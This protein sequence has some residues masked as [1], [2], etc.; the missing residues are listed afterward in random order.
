MGPFKDRRGATSSPIIVEDRAVV[1]QDHEGGSFLGTFDMATGKPNWHADRTF[2]ARSYNTPV[3]WQPQEK[4]LLV[5]AGSGLL[6]A[7]D[8]QTGRAEWIV[9]GTSSVANATA[10]TDGAGRLFVAS[11]NPGP[12]REGQ[13]TF[14]KLVERD[15]ANSNGKLEHAE[16]KTGFLNEIFSEYDADADGV[17]SK[18]EHDS[19]HKYL[20]F[21]QNGMLAVSGLKGD[22]FNRTESSTLWHVKK[23]IPRT[24]SPIYHDGHLYCINDGGVFVSLNADTG[25]IAKMGRTPGGGKYFG[26]PVLGDGKIYFASDRGEVTV[27]SAEP[28][29][30]VLSSNTVGEPCY[31]SPA[32]SGGRVYIRTESKL[33]CF[34]VK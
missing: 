4:P 2:F 33:F 1:L 25:K 19:I 27:V 30:E 17:L 24:A 32:I 31:P 29:W 20:T 10:V 18:T 12:K 11:A 26:S 8:F 15:D 5:A 14:K 13:L 21:C 9:R 28:E 7:Y 3:L 34:A 6:T 22:A 23:G 16:L